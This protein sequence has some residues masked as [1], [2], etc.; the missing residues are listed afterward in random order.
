MTGAVAAVL[1][2]N[3][4]SHELVA[5]NLARTALPDGA[6][7]VVVDNLT[8]SAERAAM[9]SL[10]ADR[11]WHLVEPESNLGFG[12][13]MNAAAAEA[14]RRGAE[15]FVLLNPDAHVEGDGIAHLVAAVE[16]DH[17]LMVAPLV[18]RPDGGHF[19][20][21]MELDLDRGS[22]RRVRDGARYARS[23]TWLSGACLAVH[24]SLWERVGGFD[25]DYFL[26]WEDIDLSVRVAAAGGRLRVD[27]EVVAVHSAGGTQSPSDGDRAK[28]PVYYYYNVRNRLVFAAQHLDAATQRRWRRRSLPAAW[29]ILLRGGR[30]Q[31][32]HPSRTFLPAA[33]GTLS[34]LAYM[35][36]ARHARSRP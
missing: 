36:A 26:Y 17:D 29:S 25:D 28:S 21:E 24:R 31:F 34:G 4:G 19:S 1:V 15:V 10:A 13:G 7:V 8:T 14:S 2:V 35:R 20:S 27:R 11:R 33:R 9:R 18:L 30:R 5:E 22:V 3:Y 32:L 6:L 16:E 12:A 23:A